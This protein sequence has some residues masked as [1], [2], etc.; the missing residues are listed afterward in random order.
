MSGASCSSRLSSTETETG[1]LAP[2]WRGFVSACFRTYLEITANGVR[3]GVMFQGVPQFP[4]L[5]ALESGF[6]LLGADRVWVAIAAVLVLLMQAGFLCLEAGLVRSINRI[7]VALKNLSDLVFS[8]LFYFIIGFG[9]MFGLS[10]G[11]L[12]GWGG[13]DLSDPGLLVFLMYQ[14]AFCGTAGTIISGV[15]AERMAFRAYLFII[16]LTSC[17]TYP[18]IG[19]WIWGGALQGE[20]TGWLGRLGFVDFAGGTVVHVVGGAAALAAA[21]ALGP[22]LGRFGEG[23]RNLASNDPTFAA[24]GT[25]IIW[26]GWFGFNGGSTYAFNDEVPVVL[27]NTL[28]AGASGGATAL[29]LA[30]VH[31]G[32]KV[33]V[34]PI[35]CGL[36][37]G[38][39]SVTAGALYLN[40]IGAMMLGAG[41]GAIALIGMAVLERLEIDDVVGAI[42]VH[43][44]AGVWGTVCL[45]LLAVR[46]PGGE[47]GVTVAALGVQVIGCGA[48]AFGAFG[49]TYAGLRLFGLVIPI[50]VTVEH[51]RVGLN[52]SEHGA[53]T[54][55]HDL[56][57]AMY[58]Q[59]SQQDFSDPVPVE[60]GTETGQV[61]TMYNH[62]LSEMNALATK[63]QSARADLRE[64]GESMRLQRDLSRRLSQSRGLEEALHETLPTVLRRGQLLGI[65][66]VEADPA[67]RILGSCWLHGGAVHWQPEAQPVATWVGEA[68]PWRVTHDFAGEAVHRQVRVVPETILDPHDRVVTDRTAVAEPAAL[69]D[70]LEFIAVIFA[71]LGTPIDL[72]EES[73]LQG[74]I[75]ELAYI[76]QRG[77]QDK[78]LRDALVEAESASVAKAEFLA[79]M[80]HEIRTPM[81]GVFGM[82]NLLASTE[83]NAE[84]RQY[85]DT[86]RESAE[87]LLVVINDILDFSKF[88]HG[89]FSLDL[90]N[91]VLED[92]FAGALEVVRPKAQAKDLEMLVYAS[93][94]LPMMLRGDSTRLRQVL[95]NLLGNAVKFTD[96]GHV[97]LEVDAG[98]VP[99]SLSVAVH[100]TGPGIPPDRA[101][102]LFDM[103]TQAD[104]S[105]TR[106]HGGTGL[107]L[108]ICRKL[109]TLMEG[110]IWVDIPPG[111]RRRT[112]TTIRF[113]VV[114]EAPQG[115]KNA[116]TRPPLHADLRGRRVL[117]IDDNTTNLEILQRQV[118]GWEM[119]PILVEDPDELA[120]VLDDDARYD[121]VVCDYQFPK[122][123]GVDVARQIHAHPDYAKVPILLL[124]SIDPGRDAVECALLERLFVR[125]LQKPAR[126][127]VLYE[128]LALA[129]GASIERS[130]VRMRN[131]S[132]GTL[133]NLAADLPLRLMLVDDNS[134]NRRLGKAILAKL[135]YEPLMAS[136][137]EEAL[138]ILRREPVDLVLLDLEM[139]GM[140]GLEVARRIRTWGGAF[141]TLRIVALTAAAMAGDR[142]RC[143]EAGMD[144]YVTKPLKVEDLVRVLHEAAIN[145]M[146]LSPVDNDDRGTDRLDE[147]LGDDHEDR[148]ATLEEMQFAVSKFL[149]LY[150]AM[151][152]RKREP[153]REEWAVLVNRAHGLKVHTH[154]IHEDAFS[155][156]LEE[157][158]QAANATS[159][160]ALRRHESAIRRLGQGALERLSGLLEE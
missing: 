142:E 110:R 4:A 158:E 143:L 97:F 145:P 34:V 19:H 115:R 50:R 10:R 109:V 49:L 63:E 85:A 52:I 149:L 127:S 103:F 107:G 17:L 123:T 86:I 45:P 68:V 59:V 30:M 35:L 24:L 156:V 132:A 154:Y 116:Q 100:D 62:V 112:G 135:G 21:L 82:S 133:P 153:T 31:G 61:A 6:Q 74:V 48:A 121:V 81:N 150:S 73:L 67:L 37:A 55:T 33:G 140:D 38:L 39:V 64:A 129:L 29:V 71:P 136:N 94:N 122:C 36:L 2:P 92:V 104:L 76:V 22:R 99:F 96:T 1:R 130:M 32:G 28:L 138:G 152:D 60:L 41:G 134:I 80:S 106:T 148:K 159:I 146:K 120:A 108:A 72:C 18:L 26:I 53:N 95:L 84:Q 155:E 27:V 111:E 137:G 57:E 93:P 78:T 44:F 157:I 131:D 139:P 79:M 160:E 113:D 114:L 151:L 23:R 16:A 7:N 8:A 65:R 88:T 98:P 118:E 101:E 46:W 42:P 69:G 12:W 89:G 75:S 144:D 40:P 141:G 15:V 56:L 147:I 11:G 125:R 14:A 119:V 124:A 70:R 3:S 77:R 128:A 13:V 83:L 43:L 126:P 9:V 47:D 91:F 58:G 87:A 90:H 66:L 102:T 51:E 105:T 54:A 20:A 117:V 5:A 25:V